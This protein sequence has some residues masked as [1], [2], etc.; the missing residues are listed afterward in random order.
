MEVTPS[1]SKD[2]SIFLEH[3]EQEGEFLENSET[4][5]EK[6]K[7]LKTEKPL[8]SSDNNGGTE[9]ISS[10]H[11]RDNSDDII[12]KSIAAFEEDLA[13]QCPLCKSAKI[14]AN[15]TA[16]GKVYY[17]CSDKKCNFVSWGKPY[18]MVCPQCHNPF[19]VEITDRDGKMII[20]CPR[21]TCRYQQRS[22]LEFADLQSEKAG[23]QSK[24][25]VNKS[26]SLRKPRRKVVRRKLVRRK[27]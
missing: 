18:H 25:P 10:E 3:V 20:K 22:P 23:S 7:S 14:Q 5:L 24:E 2:R 8:P 9:S 27:K 19:L 6:I 26:I 16:M 11:D 1:F 17:K 4:F 21:A 12:E 15:K 13:M